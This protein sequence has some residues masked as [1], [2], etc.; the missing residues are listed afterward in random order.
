MSRPLSVFGLLC[1]L[2]FLSLPALSD[3]YISRVTPPSKPYREG[4]H[5]PV[6]ARFL[7]DQRFDLQATVQPDAGTRIERVRFM[8]DGKELASISA[9]GPHPAQTSF[10]ST[11]LVE[12]LRPGS[13][14]VSYRAYS[15]KKEG[16]HRLQVEA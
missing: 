7:P 1:S 15:L 4:Q 3:P 13:V 5:E 9:E 11:G 14:V 12:G 16:I 8:I 10:V 2:F 6:T